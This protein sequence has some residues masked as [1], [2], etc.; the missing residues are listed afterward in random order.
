MGKITR[1][2]ESELVGIIRTILLEEKGT[3]ITDYPKCVQK[4]GGLSKSPSG[5]WSLKPNSGDYKGY[6]FYYNGRVMDKNKKMHDYYCEGDSLLIDAPKD[7]INACKQNVSSQLSKALN[8]W[9]QWLKSPQIVAKFKKNNNFTQSQYLDVFMKYS[10]WLIKSHLVYEWN[11]NGGYNGYVSSNEVKTFPGRIHINCAQD[12]IANW[13]QTIV[14]EM[15]HGLSEIYP[16]NPYGLVSNIMSKKSTTPSS[17][18]ANRSMEI[19]KAK[20]DKLKLDSP[21]VKEKKPYTTDYGDNEINNISKVFGIDKDYA[22]MY[23][24]YWVEQVKKGE[25]TGDPDYTCRPTEKLSNL[26][27][28][29]AVFF[30]NPRTGVV[31]FSKNI[32]PQLLK[33]YFELDANNNNIQMLLSCWAKNGFRDLNKFLNEYNSLAKED[34]TN[35]QLSSGKI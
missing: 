13:Y 30:V 5:E 29:R 7:K 9:I 27:A 10:D 17:D 35:N 24:K 19:P 25:K 28:I 18:W 15:Q 11:P 22:E 20:L 31:D 26:Q 21:K 3:S 33:P 34:G 14:H 2:T 4:F 1:L 23:A 12:G 16:I 6:Q 32:T 8:Y